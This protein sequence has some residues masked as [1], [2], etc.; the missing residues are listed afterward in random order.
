MALNQ[1]TAEEMVRVSAW[2]VTAADSKLPTGE[3][4]PTVRP[5]LEML[6]LVS[7]MVPLLSDAHINLQNISKQEESLPPEVQE[8]NKKIKLIDPRHDDL[9]RFVFHYIDIVAA[10]ISDPKEKASLL[11][12][13]QKVFPYG[14]AVINWTPTREAG[15]AQRLEGRLTDEDKSLLQSLT[16][17]YKALLPKDCLEATNELI[18]KGKLLGVL[19]DQK[20]MLLQNQAPETESERQRKNRWM[21]LVTALRQMLKL[22]GISEELEAKILSPLNDAERAAEARGAATEQTAIDIIEEEKTN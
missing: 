5:I 14:L 10:F 19:E 8:L 4:I 18:E 16:T 1:L 21:T 20:R 3:E 2:W 9:C 22:S 17:S 11:S 7:P 6:P 12:L 15:A 13:Q